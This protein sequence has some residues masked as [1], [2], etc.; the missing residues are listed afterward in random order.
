MIGYD[1][2]LYMNVIGYDK[3]WFLYRNVIGYDKIWFLYRNVGYDR[4]WFLFAL[5]YNNVIKEKRNLIGIE[6]GIIN[7]NK[8]NNKVRFLRKDDPL[9]E[10]GG[11]EV[12]ARSILR[13]KHIQAVGSLPIG[14]VQV[15]NLQDLEL[16]IFSKAQAQL[17][18]WEAKR[19]Q[20]KPKEW[21]QNPFSSESECHTHS[22]SSLQLMEM[23]LYRQVSFT[24]W[25]KTCQTTTRNA[26][27]QVE[28]FFFWLKHV[29]RG[30]KK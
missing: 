24:V 25:M 3:I 18:L 1:W 16:S 29:K 7:R 8:K 11:V 2:F 4:I 19:N 20:A 10:G 30:Y 28:D 13:R 15:S 17:L 14:K 27:Q 22:Q 12:R 9:D 26:D 5:E 23:L 21:N 6:K